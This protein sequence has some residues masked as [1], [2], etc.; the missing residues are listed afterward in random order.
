MTFDQINDAT[1]FANGEKFSSP[2]EVRDYF[3]VDNIREMFGGVVV[4]GERPEGEGDGCIYITQGE[5]DEMAE[6]VI[7]RGWWM[8]EEVAA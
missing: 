5:L 3:T 6:T 1:G 2:A 8:A 4:E 7:E